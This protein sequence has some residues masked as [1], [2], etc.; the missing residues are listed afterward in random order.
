MKTHKLEIGV[1]EGIQNGDTLIGF[2]SRYK[3]I[4]AISG[5]FVKSYYPPIPLGM[6]KHEGTVLN[7]GVKTDLLTGILLAKGNK[8]SIVPYS[9]DQCNSAWSEC[10][11]AGPLLASG[12]TAA[13]LTP[14]ER[15]AEMKR[16]QAVSRG[17]APKLAQWLDG[18]YVYLPNA[19]AAQIANSVVSR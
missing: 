5:G 14:E 6:V 11:Q 8:I 12:G 10:L 15:S 4:A 13:K 18:R 19:Q 17:E 2:Q 1:P 16:R 3:A 9:Q 7:R